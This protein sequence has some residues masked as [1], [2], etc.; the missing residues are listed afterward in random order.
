MDVEGPNGAA[1]I[2][3]VLLVA[4]IAWSVFAFVQ[5]WTAEILERS[6]NADKLDFALSNA[7][8]GILTPSL[9]LLGVLHFRRRN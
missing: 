2:L 9:M 6:G 4:A 5:G 1:S 7:S 3:G 8:A